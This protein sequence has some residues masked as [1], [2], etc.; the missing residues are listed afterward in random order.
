MHALFLATF[1]KKFNLRKTGNAHAQ[2]KEADCE[3]VCGYP[4]G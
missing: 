4:R 3:S 2:Q 1:S